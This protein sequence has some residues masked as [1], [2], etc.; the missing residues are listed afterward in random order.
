[1]TLEPHLAKLLESMD[2][3]GPYEWVIR[4]KQSSEVLETLTREVA[5]NFLTLHPKG[6]S[7]LILMDEFDWIRS[8]PEVAR[9]VFS[10][11]NLCPE[12]APSSIREGAELTE[13][14]QWK[15]LYGAVLNIFHWKFAGRDVCLVRARD[16][17]PQR[18]CY[19]DDLTGWSWLRYRFCKVFTGINV[20]SR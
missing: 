8:E 16:G 10:I 12:T 18:L 11:G 13:D 3:D 6:C 14:G 15:V 19:S 2:N 4:A 7:M 1:M 17:T 20:L 9:W 5:E